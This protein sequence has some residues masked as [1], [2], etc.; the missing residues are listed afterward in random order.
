MRPSSVAV[1]YVRRQ[2]M[3]CEMLERLMGRR[4]SAKA[5]ITESIELIP[6]PFS[7]K[8]RQSVLSS[9]AECSWIAVLLRTEPNAMAAAQNFPVGM[10]GH[11]CCSTLSDSV[12]R[13]RQTTPLIQS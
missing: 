8:Y 10:K 7:P 12:R 6:P 5:V 13:T 3:P 9:I 2:S 11:C 1:R 4:L